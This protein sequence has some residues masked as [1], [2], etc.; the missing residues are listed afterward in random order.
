MAGEQGMIVWWDIKAGGHAAAHS[1]PHEQ[2]VW[3]VTGKMDFRIGDE[4]RVMGPGDVAV[5][6]GGVEHEGF[7]PEDTLVMDIF[8]PPRQ[9]FSTAARRP[10]WRRSRPAWR[11]RRAES[12]ADDDARVRQRLIL[13]YHRAPLGCPAIRGSFGSRFPATISP[14]VPE[15]DFAPCICAASA[16][17]PSSPAR[18]A[19]ASR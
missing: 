14:E 13:L 8:A 17:P 4:C 16:R 2:L 15:D 19:A 18:I 10:T 5:I 6:P 9:D 12:S 1:H 3:M 7:F 11:L